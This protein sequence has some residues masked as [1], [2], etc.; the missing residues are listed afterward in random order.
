MPS[1]ELYV[2][3]WCPFCQKVLRFMDAHGIELAQRDVDVPENRAFLV[4]H[5]G[6]YQVPCLF[7]DGTALYESDDIIAYLG[8][9][10]G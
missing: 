5:G 1:L 8:K 4:E 10:F 9:L 3:Y 2:G 7:I 6:K